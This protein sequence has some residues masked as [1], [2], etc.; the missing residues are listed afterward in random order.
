MDWRVRGVSVDGYSHRRKGVPCQ[1]ACAY[2]IG[3]QVVVLAVADGAGS[4]PRSDQGSKLAVSLATRHFSQVPERTADVDGVLRGA[5]QRVRED[6]LKETGSDA[7]DF[8][9]TLTVMTLTRSWLGYVSV[10]DGFVVIRAGQENGKPQYHVLPQPEAVSEYSNETVFL[11]SGQAPRRVIVECLRDPGVN[12]VLLSTD[13]LAQA[14]LDRS[15]GRPNDTFVNA[16]F[17]TLDSPR[18]DPEEDDRS[19]AAYLGSD[20]LS[21]LNSDDKTVLRAVRP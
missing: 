18:P 4:R 15:G 9:T 5:F 20:Q 19:L 1:D 13:G 11:T 12:G 10:G 8:A 14:A 7:D 16:M 3:D 6:F 21:Q 17:R 2:E